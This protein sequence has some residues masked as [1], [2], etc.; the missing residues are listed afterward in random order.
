MKVPIKPSPQNREKI[1]GILADTPAR[2][3]GLSQVRSAVGR[4]TPLAP[5]QWSLTEVLAHLNACADLS[6][7][8]IYYAILVDNPV[9][10]DVHPQRNW[11]NLLRYDKFSFEEQLVSFTFK[12]K[13]LLGQ[14]SGMSK[15]QWERPVTRRGKRQENLYRVARSLA[16]HEF[17]HLAQLEILLIN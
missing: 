8:A 6:T 3:Q 1:L 4:S 11:A 17:E 2:L 10:P 12:R 7:E 14:L 9:L 13:V 5:D 16:L 15:S